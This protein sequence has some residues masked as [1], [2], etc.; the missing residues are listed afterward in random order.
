MIP[1][2]RFDA[3]G[4][5]QTEESGLNGI[6][7]TSGHFIEEDVRLFENS[8][9]GLNNAEATAMDPQQRKILEVVFEC[10]ESAGIRLENI[11]GQD[12]G[13]FVGSFTKYVI[14]V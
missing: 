14:L 13:T 12:I 7:S 1:K 6:R 2:E 3:N 9:F 11:S 4:F 5:H 8:F 10:F